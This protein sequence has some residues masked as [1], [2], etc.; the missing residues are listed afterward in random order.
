MLRRSSRRAAIEADGVLEE[1]VSV[2]QVELLLEARAVGLDGV[3]IQP[4]PL[5][6]L[7]AVQALADQLEDLQF[8]VAEGVVADM[9]AMDGVAREGSANLAGKLRAKHKFTPE[10]GAEGMDNVEGRL[11][12]GDVAGS[13][14]AESPFDVQRFVMD[15]DN[16]NAHGGEAGADV[17]DEVQPMRIL[18]GQIN[19]DEVGRTSRNRPESLLVTGGLAADLEVQLA[20]EQVGQALPDQRVVVHQQDTGGTALAGPFVGVG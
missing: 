3:N 18:E 14:G 5:R 10:D 4:Q 13:A 17:L 15:G 16:Q 19:R 7:V 6:D 11:F 12:F 1:F 9:G 20:A 2:F 8:T